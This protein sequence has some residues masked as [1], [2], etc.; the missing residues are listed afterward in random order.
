MATAEVQ[1]ATQAIDERA[2]EVREHLEQVSTLDVRVV[3]VNDEVAEVING[4][5][6][7]TLSVMPSALSPCSP[8][9]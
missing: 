8:F 6:P 1:R 4:V 3:N 7:L 9:R 5:H 2:G